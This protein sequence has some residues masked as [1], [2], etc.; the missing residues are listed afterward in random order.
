MFPEHN[1]LTGI[2]LLAWAKNFISL[3]TQLK[4]TF[5]AAMASKEYISIVQDAFQKDLHLLRLDTFRALL[6]GPGGKLAEHVAEAMLEAK[7]VVAELVKD[8]MQ[9]LLYTAEMRETINTLETRLVKCI[10]KHVMEYLLVKRPIIPP[11]FKFCEDAT[12]AQRRCDLEGKI[13][14]FDAARAA[15]FDVQQAFDRDSWGDD[16]VEALLRGTQATMDPELSASGDIS[17]QTAA[18]YEEHVSASPSYANAAQVQA[19]LEQVPVSPSA[20]DLDYV[21]LPKLHI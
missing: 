12:T 13:R 15:I 16:V 2:Q 17:E 8:A 1:V 10:I 6:E 19:D 21:K 5:S 4:D 11:S 20:S 18:L 14:R 7:L 9:T 3:E